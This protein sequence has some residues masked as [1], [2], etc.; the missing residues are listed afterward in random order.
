[1]IGQQDQSVPPALAEL[2]EDIARIDHELIRL[3]GERV[4]LARA[5]GR[6]KRAAGLPTLDPGREAAVVR[7]AAA[8]ARAANLDEDVVRGIFWHLIGQARRAQTED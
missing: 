2:R 1:M 5:V 3:I 7:R 4:R 6:A 8:H